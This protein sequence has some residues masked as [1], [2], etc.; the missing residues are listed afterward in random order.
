MARKDRLGNGV[1]S[2]QGG[3]M[4]TKNE[5]DVFKAICEK[6]KILS[7][8][9]YQVRDYTIQSTKGAVILKTLVG[10]CSGCNDIIV[11]PHQSVA[12][13]QDAMNRTSNP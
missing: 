11:I 4:G 8:G 9:T 5:G 13:I 12:D 6:C 1:T 7:S 3:F 10:V 2:L